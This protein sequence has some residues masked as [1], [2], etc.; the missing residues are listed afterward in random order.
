MS[1]VI[2]SVGDFDAA[3]KD[4]FGPRVLVDNV[5]TGTPILKYLKANPM[6]I[7]GRAWT[8][9]IRYDKP[10]MSWYDAGD[11]FTDAYT[12]GGQHLTRARFT[13]KYARM[14]LSLL[15]QD[16]IRQGSYGLVDLLTESI[17][18][19]TQGMQEGLNGQ[20]FDGDPTATPAEMDSLTRLVNDTDTCG[21]LPPGTY[22]TWK[23]H[24][25]EGTGT[26]AVPVSPSLANLELLNRRAVEITKEPFDLY[27]CHPDLW[28]VLYGQIE[29]NDYLAARIAYAS[30]NVVR[31]GFDSFFVN[32]IPVVSDR[33]CQGSAWVTGQSTRD[34]A[35]GYEVYGLN[36]NH[37]K[38]V[39][40]KTR[41]MVYRG[42]R[43][44]DDYDMYINQNFSWLTLGLDSRRCQGRIFNIDITQRPRAF[45]PGTVT[46]PVPSP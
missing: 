21:E 37:L 38:L 14:S 33:D 5:F 25:M 1:E 13:V 24:I 7:K 31:W 41:F 23:A 10:S 19:G 12:P 8:P 35:E 27:V 20:V 22:E 6:A 46:L 28:D 2:P 39:I 29:K 32:G 40:D 44:P 4:N 34:T 18:A 17:E 30:S 42:W 45:V 9:L 16:V 15:A 43:E 26:H 11:Q 36:F 3:T